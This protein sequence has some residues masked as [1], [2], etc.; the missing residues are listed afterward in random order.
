MRNRGTVCNK[1]ELQLQQSDS[2]GLWQGLWTITDYKVTRTSMVNA[3][4]SLADE[5]NNLYASF[6]DDSRQDSIT[7]QRGAGLHHEE[8]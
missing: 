8:A 3:D 4:I 6:Q 7:L 5:L 2:R 1:L